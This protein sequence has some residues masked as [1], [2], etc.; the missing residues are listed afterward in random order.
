MNSIPAPTGYARLQ[1]WPA[2]AVLLGWALLA[3][4]CLARM[5]TPPPVSN[6]AER[7]TDKGDVALYRAEVHRIHAGENYYLVAAEELVAR[8]YP[9]RSVFN[10]RTPLPMWLIGVMPRPVFGKV[11]LCLLGL[12][13]ML[14][15]FEAV[16]REQPN[17]WRGPL[18][19]T[20][21]L[22]GPLLPCLLSDLYVLPVL[23]AGVFIGLS[24][25]A[26]GVNRPYLGAA[27]G[28]AAVFFRELAL[29]YC[30]LGAALAAWH[31]RRGELAVWMTGLAAWAV[32]FGLHGLQVRQLIAPDA[33][34]HQ[35]GWIQLGGIAF[36]QGTMQMNSCLL[37]LPQWV[38][39]LYFV[40][41]LCGLAGWHSPL[42]QRTGLSLCLYIVAFSIV[43]QDFNR[44]WGLLISPL[45]CFGVV[46]FP[47]SVAD[48]CKAAW[49]TTSARD[50]GLEPILAKAVTGGQA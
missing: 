9:T 24:V 6:A 50:E 12:A 47:A 35:E 30:L 21:L 10:W 48:L 42:G 33:V 46:R 19:L 31:K 17:I 41:A 28:L 36:V 1:P 11:V 37:V 18:P 4:F 34:A 23:W 29:P 2:R 22:A 49:R 32:F 16:S 43:G 8:G 25:C 7:S 40:A 14:L 20:V 44:Y 3:V 15:A 39:A 38:T 26:Y 5:P 27:A 13:L 45:A